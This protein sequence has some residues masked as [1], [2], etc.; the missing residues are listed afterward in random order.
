[1]TAASGLNL[2]RWPSFNPNVLAAIPTG[3]MVPVLRRGS[4]A[5]RGWIATTW[6]G[7]EGWVVAAYTDPV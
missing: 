1:M 3:T 5:G 6:G 7:Q 2:R 4:F